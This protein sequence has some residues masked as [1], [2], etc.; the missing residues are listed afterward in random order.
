MEKRNALVAG[1]TGLVGSILV[2]HLLN[3]DRYERILVLT[4]RPLGFTH[5]KM[6]QQITDF[7]SAGFSFSGFPIDDAYC[8]LG[9]TIAKAGSEDAFYQVDFTFPVNLGK[10]CAAHGVKRLLIVSAMGANPRSRIFYNRVKGEME[11]AVSQLAVSQIQIFRPSLLMGQRAEKR[12]GEK[13]AQQMMNLLGFLFAGPLLKYKGIEAEV[14]ARAMI[15]SAEK[16]APGF[17]IFESGEM[18]VMGK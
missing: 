7:G 10:A 3:N 16:D 9:T 13:M 18:Q 8:A 12:S 14:V 5:P 15:R 6:V 4:R 17:R 11:T 2:Q 1:A